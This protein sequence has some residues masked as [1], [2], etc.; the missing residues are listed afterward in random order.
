[1][2]FGR[3]VACDFDVSQLSKLSMCVTLEK[4]RE[5]MMPG[6]RVG[7]ISSANGSYAVPQSSF[8]LAYIVTTTGTLRYLHP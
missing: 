6:C 7:R 3:L 5:A 4:E 2:G 1:M 8:S